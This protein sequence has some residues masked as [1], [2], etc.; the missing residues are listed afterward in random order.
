MKTRVLYTWIF[1]N[2]L[3]EMFYLTVHESCSIYVGLSSVK[4]TGLDY[5]S[6]VS[7]TYLKWVCQ[8]CRIYATTAFT[9]HKCDNGGESVKV[10]LHI[11]SY[12]Y[13]NYFNSDK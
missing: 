12:T 10:T 11:L 3:Y 4:V 2:F 1:S 13:K 5:G 7:Y 9:V 6:F 8:F